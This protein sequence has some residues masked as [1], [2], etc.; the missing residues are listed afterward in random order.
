MHISS[1][2]IDS[3]KYGIKAWRDKPKREK[4]ILRV[5]SFLFW[6][7]VCYRTTTTI[8]LIHYRVWKVREEFLRQMIVC[9]FLFFLEFVSWEFFLLR[10][11][12]SLS[13]S[14][15]IYPSLG[16]FLS[17]QLSLSLSLFLSSSSFYSPCSHVSIHEKLH[18]RKR[19]ISAEGSSWASPFFASHTFILHHHHA[20]FI[21]AAYAKSMYLYQN[22]RSK[23]KP[24]KL[25]VLFVPFQIK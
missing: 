11:S 5:R 16:Y 20:K 18:K 4:V 13:H 23:P 14:S 2:T 19:F 3:N 1:L 24:T 9:L 22:F 12:N 10:M 6:V 8:P 17:Y 25:N 7:I 21:N 15:E